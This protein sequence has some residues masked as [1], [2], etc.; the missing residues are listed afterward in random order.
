M[1]ENNSALTI[2]SSFMDTK[3]IKSS[4]CSNLDKSQISKTTSSNAE[5][6]YEKYFTEIKQFTKY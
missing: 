5:K 4:K 1:A 2:E 6:V 3:S